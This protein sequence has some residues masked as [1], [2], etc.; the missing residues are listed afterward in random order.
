MNKRLVEENN[1]LKEKISSLEKTI[2]EIQDLGEE[3][4]SGIEEIKQL[5]EKYAIAIK[6]IAKLKADYGKKANSLIKDMRKQ[7]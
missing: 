4:R 2:L 6:D 1:S 5:K 3:Y 7:I